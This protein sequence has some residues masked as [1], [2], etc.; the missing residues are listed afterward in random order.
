MVAIPVPHVITN[1]PFFNMGIFHNATPFLKPVC[2]LLG[3]LES[4]RRIGIS[5]DSTYHSANLPVPLS[6]ANSLAKS[7]T[8][9][10]THEGADASTSITPEFVSVEIPIVVGNL[11]FPALLPR[12]THALTLKDGLSFYHRSK[13]IFHSGSEHFAAKE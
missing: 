10:A 4:L 11:F 2:N 3:F 1:D 9:Y 12:H 6:M 5:N 13:I 8:N 7:A